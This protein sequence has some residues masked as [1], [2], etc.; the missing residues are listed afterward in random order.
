MS[1]F[2]SECDTNK[3]AL[4]DLAKEIKQNCKNSSLRNKLSIQKKSFRKLI[5][6][7]KNLYTKK[8]VEE[9]NK[10]HSDPKKFWSLLNKLKAKESKNRDYIYSISP[11]QWVNYFKNLLFQDNSNLIKHA[12]PFNTELSLNTTISVTEV[13]FALKQLKNKKPLNV[14][15]FPDYFAFSRLFRIFQI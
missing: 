4:T 6:C 8:I 12:I 15:Q 9:M 14:S 7:K 1:W 10:N 11:F 3:K 2:D 13:T 5:K